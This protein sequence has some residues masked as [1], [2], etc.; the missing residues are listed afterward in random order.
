MSWAR[1][2]D[3]LAM[4]RKI[5]MLRAKNVDGLAALGLHLLANTY[6]RHNGLKGVLTLADLEGLVGRRLARKLAGILVDVTMFDKLDENTWQIHDYAEFH[7]PSDPEPDK[8][9]ADRKK[10]LSEKRAHA[11]RL[12]GLAKAKQTSSN[13]TDLLVANGK[14]CSSPVPVPVPSSTSLDNFHPSRPGLPGGQPV[15]KLQAVADA[16]ARIALE[17]AVKVNNRDAYLRRARKSALEHADIGRYVHRYPTAP[18]DSIAA[19][20]HGELGTMAYF[21]SIDELATVTPIREDRG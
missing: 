21:P 20:L 13:A 11:G 15:E 6:S 7:D 4:N 1:Y 9:A 3:E 10:E 8:S 14:Q 19:W 17:R 16:Y 18:P 2:D 5:A 12:G